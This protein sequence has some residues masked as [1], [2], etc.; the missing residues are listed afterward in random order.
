MAPAGSGPSE[1]EAV[2]IHNI[3]RRL[4][5]LPPVD[6]EPRAIFQERLWQKDAG[7]EAIAAGTIQPVFSWAAL[8]ARYSCRE[9]SGVLVFSFELER[10]AKTI[11]FSADGRVELTLA[12]EPDPGWPRDGWLATE[13]SLGHPLAID[14][15]RA[16]EWRHVIETVAQSESGLD[17]TRQGESVTLAW[18]VGAGAARVT[19]TFPG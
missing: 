14:A 13:L 9:E 2:S 18:P 16:A 19:L 12:W 15:P 11:R 4:E 6:R 1:S 17:R 7:P 5:T 10:L 3:D 8:P